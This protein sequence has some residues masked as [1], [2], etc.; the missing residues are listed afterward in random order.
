MPAVGGGFRM[1]Y[2]GGERFASVHR[3]LRPVRVLGELVGLRAEVARARGQD[4]QV[5]C[6]GQAGTPGPLAVLIR[7]GPKLVAL[8]P[9]VQPPQQ[10]LYIQQEQ[11][12]RQRV[13]LHRPPVNPDRGSQAVRGAVAGGCPCVQVF[14]NLNGICREAQV[15]HDSQQ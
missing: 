9:S 6:I 4:L 3:H 14:H 7:H 15:M 5:I 12:R 11:E 8:A 13:A 10:G 1:Q 2:P